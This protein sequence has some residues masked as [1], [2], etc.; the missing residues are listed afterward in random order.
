MLSWQPLSLQV[1]SHLIAKVPEVKSSCKTCSA[2]SNDQHGLPCGRGQREWAWLLYE[3]S[4][5]IA[6]LRE[7][8]EDDRNLAGTPQ[9]HQTTHAQTLHTLLRRQVH[10]HRKGIQ[11]HGSGGC[12]HTVQVDEK[13]VWPFSLS[14]CGYMIKWTM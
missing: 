4:V 14:G 8:A 11:S 5:D 3:A 12:G 6:I 13:R 7:V 9:P 1:G 2:C 10:L